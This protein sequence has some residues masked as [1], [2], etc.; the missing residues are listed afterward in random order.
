MNLKREC[1]TCGA[2]LTTKMV[3]TRGRHFLGGLKYIHLDCKLCGTTI[4]LDLKGYPSAQ[5]E[6]TYA[7]RYQLY[8]ELFPVPHEMTAFTEKDCRRNF[9]DEFVRR[10][11]VH[12]KHRDVKIISV[13]VIN[14]SN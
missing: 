9:H 7:V 13:E 12:L 2:R 11:E 1:S 8:G 10:H 5:R 3:F 14:E 6:R 4:N